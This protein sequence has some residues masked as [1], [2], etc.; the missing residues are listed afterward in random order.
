MTQYDGS[1]LRDIMKED[2]EH[3]R[4]LLAKMYPDIPEYALLQTEPPPMLG[5][6]TLMAIVITLLI[7][8]YSFNMDENL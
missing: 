5:I 3:I 4:E 6:R 8:I 1:D 7:V 2:N